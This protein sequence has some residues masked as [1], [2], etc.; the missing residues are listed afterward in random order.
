M[1]LNV[2]NIFIIQTLLFKTLKFSRPFLKKYHLTNAKFWD[3]S[4]KIFPVPKVS[5]R[6]SILPK[7]ELKALDPF[8]LEKSGYKFSLWRHTDVVN[9]AICRHMTSYDII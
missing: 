6:S 1:K 9:Y 5:N 3:T 7:I 2:Q 4:K 8:V